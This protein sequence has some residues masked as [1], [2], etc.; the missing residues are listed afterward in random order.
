MGRGALRPLFFFL[1]HLLSPNRPGRKQ[2]ARPLAALFDALNVFNAASKGG[3]QILVVVVVVV[4]VGVVVVFV[5]A[6]V[7]VH[8]D[9]GGGG[10]ERW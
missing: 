8:D 9:G 10:G 1:L 2:P 7:V 4:V 3:P 5:G 6:V